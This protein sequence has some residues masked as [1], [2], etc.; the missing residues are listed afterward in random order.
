M[1]DFLITRVKFL[2][3]FFLLFLIGFPL[4]ILIRIIYPL[5]HIRIGVI[6]SERIGHFA[7]DSMHFLCQ[8]DLV[9]SR[10][11]LDIF[12]LEGPPCNIFL[13]KLI[14]RELKV[15]RFVEFIYQANLYLPKHTLFYNPNLLETH[16]S[17][18]IPGLRVK[19]KKVFPF[20]IAE[21]EA[22]ELFLTSMGCKNTKKFVCLNI[23]DSLYLEEKFP[24]T[25]FSYHNYRDSDC[26]TYELAVKEL[27][28]RGYFVIRMGAKV[29]DKLIIDSDQFLDYPFC[30]SSSDFLDVWLM[31][32]CTFCISTSSGL[33]SIS[34][35]YRRPVAYVNALPIGDFNSSNPKTIWMPKTIVNSKNKPLSLQE[36]IEKK[37]ISFHTNAKLQKYNLRVIDNS[38]E[39][40][41]EVVSE[42][43]EKIVGSWNA[44]KN[45]TKKRKWVEGL[46][47]SSWKE[48]PLYHHETAF[49]KKSFGHFSELFLKKIF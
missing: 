27:I 16:R 15:Y 34:N 39:E 49:Q 5:V 3:K 32:N 29:R 23:R 43:E 1:K 33:D 21:D 18:D 12:F 4:A 47:L 30:E 36:L 31:A 48:F 9:L 10:R 6:P 7:D 45:I 13:L 25:D 8:K 40:I 22:G 44:S 20:L 26:Q 42:L 41:C 35:I 38:S 14:K 24:D 28:A 37:L 11:S 46:L 19:S 2:I 17:R